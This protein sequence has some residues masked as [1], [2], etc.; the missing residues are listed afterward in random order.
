MLRSVAG[1]AERFSANT[2][3]SYQNLLQ[4]DKVQPPRFGQNRAVAA[5]ASSAATQPAVPQSVAHDDHPDDQP[6]PDRSL[7]VDGI[8]VATAQWTHTPLTSYAA[9]R[10]R[11][12]PFQ[13][14]SVCVGCFFFSA[15]PFRAYRGGSASV[16]QPRRNPLHYS[17]LH[18]TM[19]LTT[20]P[21]AGRAVGGIRASFP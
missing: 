3:N 17:P 6:E 12:R 21:Q 15:I 20:P 10:G 19:I 8:P 1:V 5:P 7:R 9:H 2:Y 4:Y 11:S 13:V 16:R 14:A 18:M